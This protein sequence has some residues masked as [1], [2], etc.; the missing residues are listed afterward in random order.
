MPTAGNIKRQ[1]CH[2]NRTSFMTSVSTTHS[3]SVVY[4][5]THSCVLEN[6]DKQ[7]PPHISN[8]PKLTSCHPPHLRR[9]RVSKHLQA[10]T[11]YLL[12]LPEQEYRMHSSISHT[13]NTL[14][15]PPVY[16]HTSGAVPSRCFHCVGTRATIEVRHFFPEV[17]SIWELKTS[18]KN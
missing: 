7:A 15:C 9:V 4:S 1:T 6:E 16:K 8:R 13:L 11:S 3:A 14:R 12:H 5:V 17:F 2:R 18:P 10:Q